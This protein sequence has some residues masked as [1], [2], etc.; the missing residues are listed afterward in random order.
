MDIEKFM[1][2]LS[3]KHPNENEYLQAVREVLTTINDIYSEHPEFEKAKIYRDRILHINKL[4]DRQKVMLYNL[5]DCDI[6][7]YYTQED[8]VCLTVL[9]IRH[10]KLVDKEVIKQKNIAID[11]NELFSQ[12]IKQFYNESSYIPKEILI[13]SEIEDKE[14]LEKYI[15]NFS[16]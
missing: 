6:L 3:A 4:N 11:E 5:K 16:K 8:I 15:S 7:G 13:A 14:L 1:Q 2:A 10:G 12:F 9:F